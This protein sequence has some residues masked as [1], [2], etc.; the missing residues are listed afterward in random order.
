MKYK[1]ILSAMIFV[2]TLFAFGFANAEDT[3]ATGAVNDRNAIQKQIFLYAEAL[4]W[5]RAD[6]AAGKAQFLSIFTDDVVVGYPKWG[7]YFVG[8]GDN[9][10]TYTAPGGIGWFY[11]YFNMY[12]QTLS[13]T[14]ISNIIIEVNGTEAISRDR[15]THIGYLAGYPQ[16][17]ENAAHALGRH[18]GKWRKINGEWKCYQWDGYVDFDNTTDEPVD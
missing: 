5:D 1:A 6:A 18:E 3:G 7:Y 16:N 10:P 9:A 13:H 2:A 4:D 17:R 12:Q 14:I 8:K 15:Y 11:T